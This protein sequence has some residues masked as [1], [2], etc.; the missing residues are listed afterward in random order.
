MIIPVPVI[1]CVIPRSSGT[2]AFKRQAAEAVLQTHPEFGTALEEA[3][4]SG[5]R[6]LFLPCHVEPD[7]ICAADAICS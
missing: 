3:E 4:K 2:Y 7:G 5:V 6:I 1:L